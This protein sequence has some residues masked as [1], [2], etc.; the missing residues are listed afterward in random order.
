M[1]VR[2]EKYVSDENGMLVTEKSVSDERYVSDENE[3]VGDEKY[4]LVTNKRYVG[5]KFN[6]DKIRVCW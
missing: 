1:Y 6:F 3:Y 5:D 4:M 2:D